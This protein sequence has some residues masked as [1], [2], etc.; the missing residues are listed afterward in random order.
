MTE[1]FVMEYVGLAEGDGRRL[2]IERR[3]GKRNVERLVLKYEEDRLNREWI[4]RCSMSCPGCGVRVEKSVG[5][6]HV[7]VLSALL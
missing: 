7:S 3:W 5:C 6:N 2:E 1:S 4:S